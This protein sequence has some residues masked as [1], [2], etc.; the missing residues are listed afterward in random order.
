MNPKK[1]PDGPDQAE[2]AM[3]QEREIDVYV[4]WQE[5]ASEDQIHEEK[6]F[7][8]NGV[9]SEGDWYYEKCCQ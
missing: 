9:S 5:E 3:K 7:Q 1:F 6:R 4:E 2:P 8:K